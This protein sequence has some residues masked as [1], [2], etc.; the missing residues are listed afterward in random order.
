MTFPPSLPT[1]RMAQP[2]DLY[3]FLVDAELQHYFSAFHNDLKVNTVAHLKYVEEEDLASLGMTKPEIRRLKKFFKREC[4]QGMLE[5]MK[6]V[7]RGVRTVVIYITIVQ[8]FM[9]CLHL[10]LLI[11]VPS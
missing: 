3:E 7:G 6:K 10:L 9:V 5:K 8:I 4:P 2:K 1:R 11:H